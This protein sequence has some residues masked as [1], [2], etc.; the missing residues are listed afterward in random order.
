MVL[1]RYSS[2]PL[3]EICKMADFRGQLKELG[4]FNQ[5]K[6]YRR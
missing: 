2:G 5:H 4:T 3:D 6:I 1:G